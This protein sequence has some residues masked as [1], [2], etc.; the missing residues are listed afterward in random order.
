MKHKDRLTQK[1]CE[2]KRKDQTGF[3]DYSRVFFPDGENSVFGQTTVGVNVFESTQ[4]G[5]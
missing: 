3:L 2:A 4:V 1:T 5:D